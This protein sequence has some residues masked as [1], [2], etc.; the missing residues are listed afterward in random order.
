MPRGAERAGDGQQPQGHEDNGTGDFRPV[1]PAQRAVQHRDQAGEY[2]RQYHQE[3]LHLQTLGAESPLCAPGHAH[4]HHQAAL[5]QALTV[6]AP[7]QWR[8]FKAPALELFAQQQIDDDAAGHG[9]QAHDHWRVE[10]VPDCQAVFRQ[11]ATNDGQCCCREQR[12]D[13]LRRENPHQQAGEH[14]QLDRRTHPAR[15]LVRGVG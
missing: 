6:E 4:H 11:G 7:H 10:A 1:A 3:Q 5:E 2:R 13:D 12:A 8:V 14:Q 9:D 15:R